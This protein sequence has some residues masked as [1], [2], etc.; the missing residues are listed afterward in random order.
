[1][2]EAWNRPIQSQSAGI[3]LVYSLL[4]ATPL[5]AALDFMVLGRATSGSL[6]VSNR[7]PSP[8]RLLGDVFISERGRIR[9]DHD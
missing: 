3:R 5:Y 7:C 4:N 8:G 2:E 1:M 9:P 6:L